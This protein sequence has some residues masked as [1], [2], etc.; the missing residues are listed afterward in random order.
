MSCLIACILVNNRCQLVAFI[1]FVSIFLSCKT[2]GGKL[3]RAELKQHVTIWAMTWQNQQNEC[4]PSKD[5]DQPGSDQSSLHVQ[6]VAKGPRFLHVDSKDSG[7]TGRIPRLIWVFA[8]CT[9]TLL[10]LS[11]RGSISVCYPDH[12]RTV[13]IKWCA[14]KVSYEGIL[15]YEILKVIYKGFLNLL[16]FCM[17][18]EYV[19]SI[20]LLKNAQKISH[21]FRS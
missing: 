14:L 17:L 11:C 13:L 5:S 19:Q 10:V 6:W 20:I 3:S 4:V 9:V 21:P 12:R 2:S 8:G 16:L 1:I 18:T 15:V 7:Q